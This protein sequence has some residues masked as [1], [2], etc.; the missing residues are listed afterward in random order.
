M[1]GAGA[2]SVDTV[3]LAAL[4]KQLASVEQNMVQMNGQYVK[5]GAELHAGWAGTSGQKMA[6][7]AQA[8]GSIHGKVHSELATFIKEMNHA[9]SLLEQAQAIAGKA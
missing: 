4:L 1:A 2:F 3:A 6:T 8:I 9:L 5:L 7:A